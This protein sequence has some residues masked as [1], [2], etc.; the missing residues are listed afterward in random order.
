MSC[1]IKSRAI[2]NDLTKV[3]RILFPLSE[4]EGK[5]NVKYIEVEF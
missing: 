3:K 2:I 1:E 4:A 5:C